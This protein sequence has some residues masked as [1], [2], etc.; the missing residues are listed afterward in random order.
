MLFG[1]LYNTIHRLLLYTVIFGLHIEPFLKTICET[2]AQ[3]MNQFPLHSCSTNPNYVRTEADTLIED[4]NKRFKQIIFTS[5]VN[6]YYAG[7]IPCFFAQKYL[8]YDTYWTIQHLTFIWTGVF[9]MCVLYCFP[10][11]YSDILHRAC[12]HLGQWTKI[13]SETE[14]HSVNILWSK[15]IF[16]PNGSL[17]KYADKI[18]ESRGHITSAAPNNTSH[19]RFY[20]IFKNPSVLYLI[21]SS[22]Q[23]IIIIAQLIILFFYGLEWHNSISLTFLIF[24]NYTIL[25]NLLRDYLV[26]DKIYTAESSIYSKMNKSSYD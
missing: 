3:Y 2:N 20:L 26:T 11:K 12:L 13:D 5:V 1:F 24:V 22:I 10:A 19:Y 8:Y 16:W 14:I 4:F 9:G 17:T 7:F 25:F 21:L 18:Y 23:L 6:A 15:T